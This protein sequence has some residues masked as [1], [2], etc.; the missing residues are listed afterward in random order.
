MPVYVSPEGLE[1]LKDEL[2]RHEEALRKLKKDKSDAYALSGDTWHD[3]PYYNKLLQDEKALVDKMAE[4]R[5]TIMGATVFVPPEPRNVSRVRMGS[6]VR[7]RREYEATGETSDE[8]WEIVG[9]GETDTARMRVAY[10]SPMGEI[11][12]GMAPGE[13]KK[14]NLPQGKVEYEVLE[15]YPDW[16]SVEQ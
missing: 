14:D 2:S 1:R 16:E 5:S 12:I 3:N 13:K 4:V 15:L 6:I 11:L 7:F 8:V 10:N 9:F